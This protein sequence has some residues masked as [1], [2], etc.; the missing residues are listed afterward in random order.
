VDPQPSAT[1][2]ESAMLRALGLAVTPGVPRGPNPR[3]GAVLL[4]PRGDVVGEGFHRGAGT[5]HAEVVAL[6]AAGEAARGATAVVTLE[7]CNH[8]GRTGPCSEAL[9]SAGVSRVVFAQSD[10]SP[11]AVGG[12]RRLLEAGVEVV[13]GVLA[14]AARAINPEWTF[15]V[16]HGRPFVTWKVATTLDGRAA[17]ADGSSRWITGPLAREDVHALRARVD[18]VVVGTGTAL[19]DDPHLSV[20]NAAGD[21]TGPQ[22]L[23]VVLGRRPIPDSAHVLDDAASTWLS[24]EPDPDEVLR[25]L[26]ARGCHHV[27]LE[28]GPTLGA[29]FVAADCVDE[30]AAY[31]AP[32]LLGA[33]VPMIGDLGIT[34][35][36]EARRFTVCDVVRFGDDVR[37]TLTRPTED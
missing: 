5:A 11:V 32:M 7:P 23:R 30:V 6:A 28:G 17:A 1:D 14:D 26:F 3:V 27:L 20:R 33:G 8:T 35:L 9:V 31:V 25:Q 15:A 13:G 22:P 29:A 34:T 21:V 24:A 16:A 10:D 18:A 19:A 37:I 36:T 4:G 12:A 2:I